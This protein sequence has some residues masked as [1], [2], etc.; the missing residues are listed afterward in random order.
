MINQY[1]QLIATVTFIFLFASLNAQTFTRITTGPVVNTPGDSRSVNWID[2]NDDGFNDL[3]ITNGPQGGQ[4]NFLYINDGAGGFTSVVND[5]IVHDNAP[6]DGA[7]FADTD[8]DGDQDCYIVNWYNTSNL[9]YTNNG[10]G[11]FT[12]PGNII[13]TSGGFCETA[14]WGDYDNDGLVDLYVT[15]SAGTNK[16]L[17]F[18]NDGNNSFTKIT[19]GALVNDVTNSRSV[20]WTDIDLDGDVDLFV[21]NE[22]NQHESMYRNDGN[23]VFNK[24][25]TGVLVTDGKNTMS[26]AW[27]DYDNDGDMDVF[28]TN[29][30]GSNALFRNDG[31]FNF[32]KITG[33]TVSKTN[34]HSFSSAWSDI[35][36]DGDIDLFVTNAF[37]T[38]GLQLNFLYLNDGNGSFTRLNNTS[39]ATDLSW[40][41]G[42]AFG[43]YDN[44][45]F[46]DLAV[47]TVRYNS[48]DQT[49]LLYHNDGN[50][51]HWIT[52][53]LTGTS[54]NRSAIGAKI[55]LKT[56]INGNA[57]WQM[58]EIS[59]QSS[60]CGQNDLRAHFGLGNA[61]SIDS[62][63]VEWPGTPAEY[64]SAGAVDQFIT[65]V[66]GQGTTGI[67]KIEND[68]TFVVWPNP[69]GNIL[70]I[71]YN[72]SHHQ[73]ET[74]YEI[75]DL[76][77]AVLSTGFMKGDSI[78]IRNILKGSYILK[79]YIS[80]KTA[81]KQ[82]IKE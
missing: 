81:M 45:G 65:L 35:D 31:N 57:V 10:S 14:S 1:K 61:T 29:D 55:K 47:A 67:N 80:S 9:F 70:Y 34:A 7:T 75:L 21:T 15:N 51:N 73:K 18:H 24:L 63:K 54:A 30:A 44:D 22:S 23:G 64:F 76:K 72:N 36:N 33:D 56:I 52:I 60:Y 41:Y 6:S 25:T 69:A 17:L 37:T 20:N 68:N 58:R 39:P 79:F 53:K 66:Q 3:M 43:D 38:P 42:C 32:T 82:F 13:N 50:S 78:D 40:S 5:T 4:N 59:A 49:D 71:T 77:G 27:A 11:T 19:T 48:V 12:K 2:V 16:N 62:I 8:N 26:S 74:K 28:L 46:E